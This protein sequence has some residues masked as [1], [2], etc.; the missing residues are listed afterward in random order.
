[1]KD[2]EFDKKYPLSAIMSLMNTEPPR[3]LSEYKTPTLFMVAKRGF[4]GAKYESYLK[5]LFDRLPVSSKKITEIDGSVYWM[6]SHPKD[7][8]LVICEW[9]N[10]TI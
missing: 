5:E 8:A 6:L 4:G 10:Q 7:A 2:S 1:M 3:P 9:F